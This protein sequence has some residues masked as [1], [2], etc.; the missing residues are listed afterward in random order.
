M[1]HNKHK[2]MDII[3]LL[4]VLLVFS[5]GIS[6]LYG[7]SVAVQAVSAPKD[8]E[9]MRDIQA[10]DVA[11]SVKR[12]G[13]LLT[14]LPLEQQVR[15]LEQIFK[16]ES[17]ALSPEEKVELGI[18]LLA[19]RSNAQEQKT[20]L[21]SINKYPGVLKIPILYIAVDR[22]LSNA[23]P[24]IKNY[25]KDNST[26]LMQQVYGALAHAIKQNNLKNF[27]QIISSLGGISRE[28]ATRLLWDLLKQNK[29]AQFIPFLV[30]QK[31]DLDEGF[32]GKTPL[33]AAVDSN[34]VEMVQ[35]LLDRGA[36]VNKFIDPA[37]GTPLQRSLSNQ[38]RTSK[39]DSTIELLLRDRGARE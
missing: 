3:L 5:C 38:K 16:G 8:A 32:E 22:K 2:Q 14:E 35:M 25:Y 21:D 18:V 9:I 33:V 4:G 1:K 29:D 19:K 7:T 26:Q 36:Q 30:D 31:A 24:Q 39:K 17:S 10:F 37:I 6:L 28:M 27:A 23:V 15:I 11:H 12:M 34:N 13:N 20:I